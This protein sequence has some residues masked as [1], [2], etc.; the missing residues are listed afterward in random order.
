MKP[1]FKVLI[2]DDLELNRHL[3]QHMLKHD[4]FDVVL[5]NNGLEALDV[6]KKEKPDLVLLDVVMP[7]LDGYETAP[8]LK[9]L[10]GEVYLPIIFITA[11][12]DQ[13]SLTRCLD[14]GGDDFL[15]KPFERVILH[16]KIK[17]HA[18]IR[19]LSQKAFE[20][21][22]ELDFY[23]L[24]TEREHQIVEHIFQRAFEGNY[25][26]PHLLDFHLSPASMFN[27]DIMLVELGPTGNLYIMMGDF[28]GHGLAAAVGTL[29]VS[30][31]FYSMV[32]KGLSVGD[33]AIQ[34]N[35]ILLKLLPDD[36]FCAAS[37]I[38]LNNMGKSLSVWTGGTPDM[39]LIDNQNDQFKTIESQ[40]MALGILESDEFDAASMNYSVSKQEQLIV[41]TDGLVEIMDENGEMFGYERLTELVKQPHYQEIPNIIDELN[42][43]SG[44]VEQDDDISILSLRCDEVNS[45]LDQNQYSYSKLAHSFSLTVD[46][47]AIRSS[48]PVLE[49]IDMVTLIKGAKEHR[50]TLYLLLSEAYNNALEHGLLELSSSIKDS[51]DGFLDYYMQ[52]DSL[53]NELTSGHI[54]IDVNY[55]PEQTSLYFT[56]TDSGKGFNVDAKKSELD[57][58]DAHGRGF[59]LLQEIAS[60]VEY[61]DIGNQV[62]VGYQLN[63]A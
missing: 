12:E 5:A 50:S 49:V 55:V 29:P 44:G 16:A 45:N 34:I 60:S 62:K 18:R 27:G 19:D 54:I 59:V 51:D 38:E 21:K 20:Q 24:K 4:G 35:D 25:K 8:M 61:N 37:I 48:D 15:S 39:Y 46:A 56:V 7:H 28:T 47:E 1:T 42:Y 11:L 31:S 9:E 53:L 41:F 63:E 32:Q 26:V 6:Y 30:S 10:A 57:N 3:L 52:R 36:M 23:R 17:A 14:V 58:E 13:D 2:V 40:H 22:K 33:I 43:F